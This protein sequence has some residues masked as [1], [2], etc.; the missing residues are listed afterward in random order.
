MSIVPE[1]VIARIRMLRLQMVLHSYIYYILDDN[2]ITDHQ[3]QSRADELA[4]LQAQYGAVQIGVYDL[5][6]EDWDGSTG[7]HLPK[8]DWAYSK[9]LQLLRC[10]DLKLAQ[11]HI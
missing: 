9:S 6:F 10:R 8:D 3:W 5:A 2:L 1:E 11:S 4:Q 7:Y